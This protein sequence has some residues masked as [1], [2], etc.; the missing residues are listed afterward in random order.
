M[1]ASYSGNGSAHIDEAVAAG[2]LEIVNAVSSVFS[3]QV[4]AAAPGDVHAILS[5]VGGDR[6][7]QAIAELMIAW[8][9]FASGAVEHDNTVPL[10][11]HDTIPF[12]ELMF[13]AEATISNPAASNAE[14]HAVTQRLSRVTT[15][16]RVGRLDDRPGRCCSRA[17]LGLRYESLTD[18]SAT[19]ITATCISP[20]R[21][22]AG[23]LW[24]W[25]SAPRPRQ[26]PRPGP[27][28][29]GNGC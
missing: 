10:G 27:T 9:Q 14:L 24:G 26:R 18:I 8:L 2:Y 3:E 7:A 5:P 29:R 6:R 13:Q 12:L 25:W 23:L 15:R 20:R 22:I 17:C 19:D 21:S 11:G 16:A 1:E 4:V 28:S